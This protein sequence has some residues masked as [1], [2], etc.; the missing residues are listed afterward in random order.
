MGWCDDAEA[1][2]EGQRA[3]GG[4]PPVWGRAT[5]QKLWPKANA[6]SVVEAVAFDEAVF[7]DS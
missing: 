3:V 6:G 2:A 4:T 5:T 1:L 7:Q